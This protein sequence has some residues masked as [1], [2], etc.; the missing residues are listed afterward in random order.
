MAKQII[1]NARVW[2]DQFDMSGDF[3]AVALKTGVDA[4]EATPVSATQHVYLPGL[5][6]FDANLQGMW[7]GGTNA[8]DEILSARIGAATAPLVTIDPSTNGGAEGDR[9]YFGPLM[10]ADYQPGGSIGDVLEF[11]LAMQAAGG[12]SSG[13]LMH[14]ATRTV[15]GTGNVQQLV[16]I[17]AGRSLLVGAHLLAIS[18][19]GSLTIA[20]QS[21]ALVGFGTPTTRGTLAAMSVV[22]AQS[23]L[24]AGAITDTFYRITWTL[25]GASPSAQFVVSLGLV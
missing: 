17:P 16:A 4:K 6:T 5:R 20:V 1:S 22:G 19:G 21:A 25:T 9:V 24:I 3:N 10:L 23:L 13:T 7:E 15:T 14:N 8:N 11:A 12:I 18:G 2:L